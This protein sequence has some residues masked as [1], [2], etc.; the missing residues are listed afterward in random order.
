MIF[1]QFLSKKYLHIE[2]NKTNK[3]R[4]S[5]DN[6]VCQSSNYKITV[7]GAPAINVSTDYRDHLWIKEYSQK[8]L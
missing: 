8:R 1:I 3:W 4:P 7:A 2:T 5:P 6:N